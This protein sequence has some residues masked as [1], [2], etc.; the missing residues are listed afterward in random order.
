[1]HNTFIVEYFHWKRSQSALLELGN[2]VLSR[3]H[4]PV[5]LTVPEMSIM[6]N[7]ESRMNLF[8]FA[9]EVIAHD[10]PGDFVEVGCHTGYSS[11][12]LQKVLRDEA[13]SRTLH[14]Y[15]SF[16]GLPPVHEKDLGAYEQGEM[17]ASLTSFEHTLT[18]V[19]LA[20]PVIH[21]GWFKDT[22]PTGL[23]D[24]IAFA[25]LDA[26]LYESTLTALEHV[27]PRLSKGAIGMFHVYWDEGVYQPPTRSLKY[28][29][30]GV[31]RAADEFFA[32][33]PEKISV[34]YSGDYSSGYFYKL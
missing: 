33:K 8:H 6:G 34:L 15:D 7:V 12:V 9:N 20:L 10:V 4:V 32:D 14:V 11:V 17:S 16:E 2:K 23:P 26:D 31:K 13:P 19:G 1:M 25:L 22:L 5:R 28:L 21:K 24:R 29:S 30:P 18:S 3:L 27:Y